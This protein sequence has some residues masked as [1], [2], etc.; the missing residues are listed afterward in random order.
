[1]NL[2]DP[3]PTLTDGTVVLRRWTLADLGCV[4]SASEEGRIQEYTSI[5]ERFTEKNGRAWVQRQQA[6]TRSGQ[7]WSLAIGDALTGEALG[8]IVL[9]LRPQA[10]VAGV[11]YWLVPEARGSGYATR[12]VRLLG[13]WGLEEQG[14]HRIE[15]WVEPY[16]YWRN[17]YPVS[18]FSSGM[19]ITF[20]HRSSVQERQLGNDSEKA[21]SHL[22]HSVCHAFV[23]LD[24]RGPL[25]RTIYAEVRPGKLHLVPDPQGCAPSA[26]PSLGPTGARFRWTRPRRHPGTIRSRLNCLAGMHFRTESLA[27]CV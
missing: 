7:G 26:D 18:T 10:V 21:C 19:C 20:E 3:K 2:E 5:P 9:M 17:D 4:R 13:D 12:A 25:L 11:G 1:M 8:C 16:K 24:R 22:A 23:Q 15:A 27:S 6:R 14:L